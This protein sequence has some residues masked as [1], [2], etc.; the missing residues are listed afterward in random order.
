MTNN[1]IIGIVTLILILIVIF[2]IF[3]GVKYTNTYG[4]ELK[5][6][7][8]ISFASSLISAMTSTLLYKYL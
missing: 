8:L 4:I 6:F 1:H 7:A 3:D 2:V 5:Q